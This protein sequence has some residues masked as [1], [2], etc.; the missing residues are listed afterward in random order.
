MVDWGY[1]KVLAV[2]SKVSRFVAVIKN[3]HGLAHDFLRAP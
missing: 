3:Q 2:G 1:C